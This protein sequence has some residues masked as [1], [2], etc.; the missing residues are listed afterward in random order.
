VS[1]CNKYK[2]QQTNFSMQIPKRKGAKSINDIPAEIFAQLN[3]GEIESA[4]WT[5][6]SASKETAY[7][8]KRALRS[9]T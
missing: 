5:T 8:V 1:K 6:E 7:I 9:I 2:Q 4:K 3:A